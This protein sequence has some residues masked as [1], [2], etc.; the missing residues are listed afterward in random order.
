M[1]REFGALE[2]HM[3]EAIGER[4]CDDDWRIRLSKLLGV[5][6][7]VNARRNSRAGPLGM[8]APA[9]EAALIPLLV[10][11]EIVEGRLA[12]TAVPDVEALAAA[13]SRAL[14]IEQRAWLLVTDPIGA[15]PRALIRALA[16]TRLGE[17]DIDSL[18]RA[19]RP[20]PASERELRVAIAVLTSVHEAVQEIAEL[21]NRE[22]TRHRGTFLKDGGCLLHQAMEQVGP[23]E[24]R[25]LP[26]VAE[27]LEWYAGAFDLLCYCE[28]EDTWRWIYEQLAEGGRLAEIEAELLCLASL[29]VVPR[30]RSTAAE[31]PVKRA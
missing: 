18:V 19:A 4:I 11:A 27:R 30:P 5:E 16:A 8:L 12:P 29:S 14:L 1:E 26:E 31:T 3:I 22:L 10:L 13:L 23:D 2:A 6:W 21:W 25:P 7:D 17:E 28:H 24:M 15:V 20:G 9:A